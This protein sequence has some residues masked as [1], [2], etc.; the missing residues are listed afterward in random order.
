MA[1]YKA[2]GV[3]VQDIVNG[4]KTVEQISSSVGILIGV[5]RN[6]LANVAQKITSWTEYISKYANG[7]D[8]PFLSNDYLSYA[9]H[10]FFTN[11]GKELYIGSVKKNDAT[12]ATLT[13]T[14]NKI[15]AVALT[16][17]VWGNEI[18]IVITKNADYDA[19]EYPAFDVTV[20]VGSNDSVVITDV[21]LDNIDT[22]VMLNSKVR[23][24][25]GV[26]SISA[27]TT[28][29]AEE[30]FTLAG[31]TDGSALED[32]DYVNALSMIDT[33]EDVTF[34]AIPGQTSTTVNDAI[35]EYCNKNGLFPI[36]D[37]PMGSTS[38]ATKAYRKKINAWTGALTHPWGKVLDPLTNSPKAVPNAGHIMGVYAR[39][40]ENYGI[41]KA[42]AGVDA[43][44]R[45]FIEME[46]QLTPAQISTLNPLGVICVTARP[47]T[48]IVVWGARS[49]NSAQST[50]RYVTDDLLNLN[51]KKF[52]YTETQFAVFEPNT[53]TLWA[54]V[55]AVCKAYLE[56]LRTSGALKGTAEQAYFVTVDSTNNTEESI[57]NGEL[58]IEIGY[59]PVKPAE[60]VIIKL[61]HSIV[62][63][64]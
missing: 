19:E 30:T 11:G 37:M 48:G 45:G 8:T 9:V 50:M 33:L 21:L 2:P 12:K 53:E 40:I 54:R 59:A 60:F 32:A 47:N 18:K 29:L 25:L 27:E 42:P 16:E 62:S 14:T 24:W 51:I 46:Y 31:G 56:T 3:Y 36:L 22:A 38:D 6:G 28:V 57:A 61:A 52:L 55:E 34:V 17:G 63:A 4:S 44:V 7:L 5:T 64:E 39:T 58:N 10:G 26:F 49:L 41:H 1:S 15:T 43:T 20:S 23:Q 13:S 35:I